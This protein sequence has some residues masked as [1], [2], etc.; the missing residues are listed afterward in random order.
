MKMIALTPE[1]LIS[2]DFMCNSVTGT[3]D[4]PTKEITFLMQSVTLNKI[5]VV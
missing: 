1:V 5:S 3:V 4:A 2:S